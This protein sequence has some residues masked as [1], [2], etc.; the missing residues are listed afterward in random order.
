VN[1]RRLRVDRGQA[2]PLLA[3]VLAMGVV[4]VVALGHL[5]EAGVDAARA[6]TAADA[7]ALA[8]AASGRG[9]A[10][11]LAA[12]NGGS[13]VSYRQAGGAVLVRVRVG[14]SVAVARAALLVSDGASAQPT[15]SDT[16][17]RP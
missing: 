7:A 11:A 5:G 10:S 12:A 13:L 14:T 16:T 3:A 2:V 6:R 4:T 9:A 1:R 8:G 15:T 17:A